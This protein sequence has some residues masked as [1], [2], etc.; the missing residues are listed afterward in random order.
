MPKK[1]PNKKTQEQYNA[2]NPYMGAKWGKRPYMKWFKAITLYNIVDDDPRFNIPRIGTSEHDAVRAIQH[3]RQQIRIMEDPARTALPSS[4]TKRQ[5][6]VMKRQS[7]QSRI[8]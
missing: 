1:N 7:R 2:M 4:E 5:H 3:N 8:V 6:R